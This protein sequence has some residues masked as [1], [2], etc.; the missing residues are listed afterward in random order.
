MKRVYL[1]IHH[2]DS[3]SGSIDEVVAAFETRDIA[4]EFAA[5]YSEPHIY[6]Q[7]QLWCG[8]L[9]VDEI[10]LYEPNEPTY[11]CFWWLTDEEKEKRYATDPAYGEPSVSD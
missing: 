10:E 8:D 1:V 9:F 7:P 6:D 2:F 3:D 5:R 11:V 4:E